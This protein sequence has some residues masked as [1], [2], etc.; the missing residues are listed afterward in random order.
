MS[1][2][3]ANKSVATGFALGIGA[4]S[5]W[6]LLR[7]AQISTRRL[8]LE[9]LN[10]TGDGN[11]AKTPSGPLACTTVD[12]TAVTVKPQ[13]RSRFREASHTATIVCCRSTEE[14]ESCIDQLVEPADRV[15]VMHAFAD[16]NNATLVKIRGLSS[17]AVLFKGRNMWDIKELISVG[18]IDVVVVDYSD[19][20]GN[21]LLC[22]SVNSIRI[23]CGSLEPCLRT[24]IV[25]SKGLVRHAHSYV[26]VTSFIQQQPTLSLHLNKQ[27]KYQD[28]KVICAVGVTE[29]R[30]AIPLVVKEGDKVLEIGCARG[31][32]VELIADHIG[33]TGMC[34][35]VDIGKVCIN[36][37]QKEYSEL[38]K[39][40]P[41]VT[42]E[43]ADAWDIPRLLSL[44][45]DFNVIFVDV[46]GISGIDGESEGLALIRQLMCSYNIRD[47]DRQLRYIVVKSQCLRDH[48]NSFVTGFDM[49]E[50]IREQNQKRLSVQ[51][52]VVQEE[53]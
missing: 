40:K 6:L 37:A 25:K 28:P 24:I 39:T 2:L 52:V 14:Y 47:V 23:L 15:L 3:I 43:I 26:P 13:Q 48:A 8:N 4:I 19:Y 44:A 9:R 17:E 53:K 29:Y 35:G 22:D 50:K 1:I 45:N 10:K 11:L 36:R 21:F 12:S 30:S 18:S 41:N 27:K 38:L 49:L 51:Q 42:F 46:G 7:K 20:F 33:A 31:N 16:D 5:A 32:T 34:I